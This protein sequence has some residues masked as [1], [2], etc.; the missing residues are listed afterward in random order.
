MACVC[1]YENRH[2]QKK[3]CFRFNYMTIT[4]N[5]YLNNGDIGIIEISFRLMIKNIDSFLSTH[6]W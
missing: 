5:S 3:N 6:K 1:G 4:S 2:T